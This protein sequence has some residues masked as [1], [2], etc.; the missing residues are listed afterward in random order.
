M[1]FIFGDNNNLQTFLPAMEGWQE[2]PSLGK[3]QV[4][5]YGFV[6]SCLGALLVGVLLHG[7]FVRSGFL[8]T[9][10]ILVLTVPVHELI[11]AV[12]T[13]N[14]GPLYQNHLRSPEK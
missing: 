6:A 12:F 8:L 10:L 9:L 13:P 1:R 5:S 3:K 4:Q 14:W 2:A 7:E 11:H